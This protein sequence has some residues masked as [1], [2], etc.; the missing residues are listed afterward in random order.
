MISKQ[1]RLGIDNLGPAFL[2]RLC[3]ACVQCLSWSTQQ[4]TVAASRTNACLKMKT[5]RGSVP[6]QNT[7]PASVS[8][9]SELAT[10]AWSF[11]ATMTSSSLGELPPDCRREL[12]DLLCCCPQ[13]VQAS[14]EVKH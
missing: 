8:R 4:R 2:K 13:P 10:S 9:A 1:L 3:N 12:S 5:A 14:H 7:S 11:C 6:R